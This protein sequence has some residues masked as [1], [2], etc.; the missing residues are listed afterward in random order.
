MMNTVLLDTSAGKPIRVEFIKSYFHSLINK[1]FKILPM[2]EDNEVTLC[3]YMR[4][5]QSELIGFQ[6][7]LLDFGTD[8][9]LIY[10]LS[11]L[12]YLIDMHSCYGFELN[13][14]LIKREVFGA[15]S[16]CKKM[17]QRC[18]DIISSRQSDNQ[19]TSEVC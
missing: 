17:E 18:H 19:Q 8:A 16:V 7:L 15:I 9:N 3:E 4:N 1:F 6:N 12:E 5:L 10:L 14:A 13:K 2:Y 11:V